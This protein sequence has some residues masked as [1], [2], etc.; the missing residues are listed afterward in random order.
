MRLKWYLE[1]E[2]IGAGV[3]HFALSKRNS[4]WRVRERGD[5]AVAARLS[6]K[7][8]GAALCGASG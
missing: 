3:S 1:T 8:N 2:R 5:D 7:L 6:R 4:F